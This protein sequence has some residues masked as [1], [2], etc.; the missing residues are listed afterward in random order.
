[1]DTPLS[2]W[3]TPLII[4]VATFIVSGSA[5]AACAATHTR[6]ARGSLVVMQTYD[7][8][9]PGMG[10]IIRQITL[11][12]DGTGQTARLEDGKL[13]SVTAFSHGGL[14]D[15]DMTALNSARRS[16]FLPEEMDPDLIVE[17]NPRTFQFIVFG[18][19]KVKH[20]DCHEGAMPD[21]LKGVTR[22]MENMTSPS[23]AGEKGV[24]LMARILGESETRE[25]LK[26]TRPATA[27]SMDLSAMPQVET[28]IDHPYV[29]TLVPPGEVD[30]IQDGLKLE[31][32]GED[33]FYIAKG[34]FIYE[35]RFHALN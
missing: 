27:A 34:A 35:L 19:L 6:Q 30:R 2:S 15:K 5:M 33:F 16:Y 14:D 12:P 25:V 23:Q 20:I 31:K 29:Y 13:K 24:Y 21:T 1:M 18:A 22:T 17:G 3:L 28:A 10:R 32:K 4:V 26:E 11:S 9:E 7:E 8:W